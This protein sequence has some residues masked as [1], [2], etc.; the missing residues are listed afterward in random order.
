MNGAFAS[1]QSRLQFHHGRR[2]DENG[3]QRL[4][5]VVPY[6]LYLKSARETSLSPW[7]RAIGDADA[8]SV[9]EQRLREALLHNTAEVAR[10]APPAWRPAV[11]W[12]G[13]LWQLPAWQHLWRG[14]ALPAGLLLTA[15][16]EIDRLE[17]SW[18]AGTPL[19]TAWLNRWRGLW[20]ARKGHWA[21]PLE[22]LTALLYSHARQF[23]QLPDAEAARLARQRLQQ[24]LH[25]LFRRHIGQPAALFVHLALMALDFE[26]LRGGL[27]LR[28]LYHHTSDT[29]PA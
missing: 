7:L 5:R 26:R 18:R 6:P 19:L 12:T 4:E 24:R 14:E 22:Q 27:L 16:A 8:P 1:L 23:Q 25:L 9:L 3:W 11:T 17:Q 10:W 13:Q 2:L 29:E 15:S 20:P 21:P 28:A